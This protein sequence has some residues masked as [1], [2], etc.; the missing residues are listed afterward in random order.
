[1]QTVE[2]CTIC[3]K[4]LTSS[5]TIGSQ[6]VSGYLRV[7]EKANLHQDCLSFVLNKIKCKFQGFNTF[8]F[9]SINISDIRNTTHPYID[10]KIRAWSEKVRL[11]VTECLFKLMYNKMDYLQLTEWNIKRHS[12]VHLHHYSGF[13]L[14]WWGNLAAGT[15]NSLISRRNHLP[16]NLSSIKWPSTVGFS[17]LA[18]QEKEKNKKQL[19]FLAK[20]DD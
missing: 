10:A 7:C 20:T 9:Y 15:K 14:H 12:A 6:R 3:P 16:V 2:G 19:E 1:M 17:N 18:H 4:S 5:P 8:S 13:E 11:D